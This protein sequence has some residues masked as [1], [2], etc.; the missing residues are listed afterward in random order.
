L[1]APL[2]V[3]MVFMGVYPAPFLNRSRESVV[4]IEERLT[5]RADGTIGKAEASR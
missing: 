4:A 1:I 2:V 5:N 3:L